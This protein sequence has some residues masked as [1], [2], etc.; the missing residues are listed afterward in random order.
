VQT[1][2]NAKYVCMKLPLSRRREKLTF[3]NA[4]EIVGRA[5]EAQHDYWI[6]KAVES[7]LSTRALREELRKSAAKYRAEPADTGRA[8]ILE[9][10]RQYAR[11]YLAAAEKFTPALRAEVRRILEPVL[12][13][14]VG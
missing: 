1:L 11:D 3:S 14:V 10:T 4:A 7:D 9:Q 12:A 5:P 8:T 6:A 13:D 2:T